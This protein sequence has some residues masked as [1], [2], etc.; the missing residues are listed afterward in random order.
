MNKNTR[1]LK[2]LIDHDQI[3]NLNFSSVLDSHE[4]GDMCSKCEEEVAEVNHT[5]CAYCLD[6]VGAE[7]STVELEF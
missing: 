7:E 2:E 6:E 4:N 3:Y 5:L 1:V